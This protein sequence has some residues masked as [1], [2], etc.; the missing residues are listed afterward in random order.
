MPALFDDDLYPVRHA[1]LV[2]L[3][4]VADRAQCANC[5]SWLHL[6]VMAALSGFNLLALYLT[7]V[8]QYLS[9]PDLTRATVVA[10]VL[11]CFGMLFAVV[12]KRIVPVRSVNAVL[13][14]TM[15]GPVLAFALS[16]PATP[17]NANR[18]V[19]FG[20]IEFRTKPNI[21][22]VSVDALSPLT[23]VKKNMGLSELPYARLLDD[24][25]VF[26]FKNA[27]ASRVPTGPSLNNLM[28][29]AHVEFSGDSGYFAGR[30]GTQSRWRDEVSG[31]R[32]RAYR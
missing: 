4:R 14:L 29:L 31:P 25:E 12:G 10:F 3:R 17:E 20:N 15:I 16:S 7:L 13:I 28:R 6:G 2:E 19:P 26:V 11:L 24:E 9:L 1:P 23:L 30:T 27:F 18:M 21:H 22:I 5:Q 8:G 32:S